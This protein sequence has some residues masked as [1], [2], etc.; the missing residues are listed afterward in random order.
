MDAQQQIAALSRRVSSAEAALDRARAEA[1]SAWRALAE[2][3]D[4]RVAERKAERAAAVA[5]LEAAEAGYRRQLHASRMRELDTVIA[6]DVEL[7]ELRRVHADEMTAAV[8]AAVAAAKE[9]EQ[10]R[11]QATVGPVLQAL[12]KRQAVG[13]DELGA[14][15]DLLWQALDKPAAVRRRLEN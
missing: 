6:H 11:L 12:Q 7:R 10:Q 15:R 3:E 2:E 4:A 1:S 14:T 9:A 5:T 13:D 8:S